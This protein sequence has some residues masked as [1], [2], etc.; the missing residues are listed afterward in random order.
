MKGSVKPYCHCTDPDTGRDLGASC[1]QRKNRKHARYEYRDRLPTSQGYR[2]LRRRGFDTK[3]VGERFRDD[4]YRLLDLG[5]GD[6]RVTGRLGDLIFERT[7]RGGQLPDV[8]E[9][10]RR[11]GVGLD[12]AT[13][14]TTVTNQLE[15]WLAGKR[16]LKASVRRS[17]RQHLDA[18]WI[19]L[20]GEVGLD[21]LRPEHIASVL[22]RIEEWNAEI[23]AASEE[24]RAPSLPG[25][26]RRRPKV[27][28]VATQ[29][30]ILATLRAALNTAV[31]QR[32]IDW[33]PCLAVELPPERRDPARVWSP[34]Q[35]TAFFRAAED[36]RMGLLF[37]VV[38]LRGLRRGEVCGLRWEDL[39]LDA[40]RARIAQEVLQLGGRIVVDTPKTRAGERFVSLDA[41]TVDLLKA[42]RTAQKRER[43]AWGEAYRDHGLVFCREDG[44]PMPPDR[45]TQHFKRIAR[46]AGLPVI[47][48]HEAR[49]TAASLALEAGL[50]TKLVSDQLGHSTT[51]I[52][53]DL[54]Q[55]VR[56]AVHDDAA[57]RVVS[58]L[59]D[60]TD[61]T[62]TGS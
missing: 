6:D 54:Y 46:D 49:H 26:V 20:I 14:S 33:N 39:D 55:H 29:H 42:H 43:L 34:D 25:D 19:P 4:V 47:R 45:V 56:P 24:D 53:S 8:E 40:R 50:D 13:P 35:V 51:R 12:A 41:D 62:G 27:V 22:D 21:R 16:S 59:P 58:L 10:R 2:T 36:H 1:P 9:V 30:R 7:Q 48:L 31:R 38:L 37:R 32:L 44:S 28:G 61:T 52:T 60:R 57:E 3:K 5:R 23:Q 18:Y 15:S 17:Y 11:L